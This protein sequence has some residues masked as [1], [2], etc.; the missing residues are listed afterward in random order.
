MRVKKSLLIAAVLFLPLF[1][2]GQ[3]LRLPG[4]NLVEG[5]KKQENAL[6]FRGKNLFSHINGGAE[7]FLEFGFEDLVVQYYRKGEQEIGIEA[8]RM[9]SPEAALGVYL[10][11]C[12]Q[13]SPLAEIPARNSSDRFQYT[14]VKNNYFLLINNFKGEESLTPV[15]TAFT[16]SAVECL[17]PGEP[18]DL[19]SLLPEEGLSP[20]GRFIFRG[21][22]ALQPIFT[23]GKG[24]ILQLKGRIFGV[25]G[26]YTDREE[27]DFK[28]IF[29]SYPDEDACLQ[30]YQHLLS[31]LDTYI[32][33]LEKTEKGFVF[34][35]FKGQFG[36]VLR[37]EHI[38]D[39]KVNFAQRPRLSN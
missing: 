25:T 19:F 33:V 37:Q 3:E 32:T 14:V 1:L 7:L 9:E 13:E 35:D 20:H 11:K 6:H 22:F 8:Y 4:D 5:W 10:M 2:F 30:A 38:L 24:D 36:I 31:N 21:P 28:R 27:N 26:N 34:S 12:G 29:I 39:I 18:V 17:P 15:M 16:Q 23:F